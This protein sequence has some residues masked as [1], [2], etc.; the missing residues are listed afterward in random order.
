MSTAV[1]DARPPA[2]VVGALN[3]IMRVLLRTPL[4]RLVRPLALL[5][6]NGRH[7][8]RR[9]RVPVGW[10]AVDGVA[11]V[12]TPAPWRVSFAD[13][14]PAVVRHRGRRQA[15]SGTLTT[16]PTEVARALRSVLASGVKPRALGLEVAADHDVTA[17]DVAHL[18]RAMI[19][20][21]R[22]DAP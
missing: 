19:R 8:G 22:N 1:R 5:E 14:A 7:T 17:S 10:Y 3:P 2:A 6:F 13:G 12:F 11:V 20:F 4:G 18:G 9:Y 21:D 16:D 15:M